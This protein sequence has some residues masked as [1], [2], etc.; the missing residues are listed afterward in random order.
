MLRKFR[1]ALSLKKEIPTF[2]IKDIEPRDGMNRLRIRL[3]NTNFYLPMVHLNF[4]GVVE[5]ALGWF[6][7]NPLVNEALDRAATETMYQMLKKM[8]P[9]VVV[10]TN[11]TKSEN[12]IKEA[13]KRLPPGTRLVILP[14]GDKNAKVAE[15]STDMKLVHFVPVTGTEKDMGYPKQIEGEKEY[16]SL[17][18]LKELCPDGEGLVIADDVYTTGATITAMEQVLGLNEKSKHQIAVI[19]NEKEFNGEYVPKRTPK[20]LHAAFILTEFVDLDKLG[21]DR[22]K[23]FFYDKPNIPAAIV[24]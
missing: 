2:G 20:N 11:S 6:D 5:K 21:I 1:G 14:S 9:K 8:K 12:F 15:R 18:Q 19:A 23:L 17:E 22:K 7:P 3:A 24:E 10:M 16:L 13:Y 4:P